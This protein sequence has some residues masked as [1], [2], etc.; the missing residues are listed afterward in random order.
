MAASSPSAGSNRA[1]AWSIGV[2]LIVMAATPLVLRAVNRALPDANERPSFVPSIETPRPRFAFDEPRAEEIRQ[3]RPEYVIIGDSTAG[4]RINP[5]Y[6]SRL[7]HHGTAGLFHPGS[8]VA[9]WFLM[10]KNFVVENNVGS[11]RGA[12]IFFRDDQ[13][14]SQVEFNPRFLD[15]V[16][17]DY[18]PEL[19]RVWSAYKTGKFSSVHRAARTAYQYDRTRVWLEPQ[20]T[21]APA[22]LLVPPGEVAALVDGVNGNLF[23]LERLRHFAAADLAASSEEMLDFDANVNRSLLPEFFELA[24]RRNIR[25]GFIRVQRRPTADGPPQESPALRAY[26]E[27]F[28]AYL[29]ERG[30]YY[31][32][33]WGDPDQPLSIY[34]DGDHLR[35]DAL[36]PYTER[37]ARKH[38]SFFQ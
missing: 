30:A 20:L 17:R 31:G 21:H 34:S 35:P 26:L 18:E 2:L 19:D 36:N 9:Y 6:L 16:A 29:E 23:T 27:K 10:F 5:G 24:R 13:L 22:R 28:Q 32:D 12:M 8:P 25:L 33:D 11:V 4:G 14:T 3:S 37:F 7:V 1:A 15:N 38:A